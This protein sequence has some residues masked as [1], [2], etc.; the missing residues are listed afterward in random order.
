LDTCAHTYLDS[1]WETLGGYMD[2][3]EPLGLGGTPTLPIEKAT[4]GTRVL[5][6]AHFPLSL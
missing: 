6:V 4:L 3:E 2:M 1:T 5:N